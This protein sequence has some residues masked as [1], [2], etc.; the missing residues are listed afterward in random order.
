MSKECQELYSNFYFERMSKEGF[1]GQNDVLLTLFA[2]L[3]DHLKK[4]DWTSNECWTFLFFYKNEC[5]NNVN[6]NIL[7]ADFGAFFPLSSSVYCAAPTVHWESTIVA[8]ALHRDNSN[9]G[10]VST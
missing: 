9:F 1:L 2:I 5:Q 8:T 7:N 6:I 3:K 10:F 4:V